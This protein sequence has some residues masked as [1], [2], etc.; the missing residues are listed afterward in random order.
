M[1]NTILSG[2]EVPHLILVIALL[3]VLLRRST[4]A[5]NF[6][7]AL[8]ILSSFGA[9]LAGWLPGL[10]CVAAMISAGVLLIFYHQ[11]EHQRKFGGLLVIVAVFVAAAHWLSQ[12][13]S[14]GRLLLLVL[15]AGCPLLWLGVYKGLFV[16]TP[17]GENHA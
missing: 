4:S 9:W 7:F 1:L 6:A 16:D 14:V 17:T 13:M 8:A 15:F 11:T 12:G 2:V 3:L 5:T 10:Q